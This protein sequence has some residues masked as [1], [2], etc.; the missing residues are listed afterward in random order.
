MSTD[1]EIVKYTVNPNSENPAVYVALYSYD[2]V[3][4]KSERSPESVI[5][6]GKT[7]S[8]PTGNRTPFDLALGKANELHME[9]LEV[10]RGASQEKANL[11][12][13]KYI[14]EVDGAKYEILNQSSG[15]A[16]GTKKLYDECA[17]IQ[18][19]YHKANPGLIKNPSREKKTAVIN[20][21]M[22]EGLSV[23]DAFSQ[24]IKEMGS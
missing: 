18:Y 15:G 1:Y 2:G 14:N 16:K 24:V 9:Q 23:E 10:I 8:G 22:H 19:E 12:K 17:K 20:L 13:A 6:S 3:K 4:S 21:M 11:I 5:K 7:Q